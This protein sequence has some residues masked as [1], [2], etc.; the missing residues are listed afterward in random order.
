MGKDVRLDKIDVSAV[1]NFYREWSTVSLRY[2]A[3]LRLE[4]PY[5][6]KTRRTLRALTLDREYLLRKCSN[7]D[8]YIKIITRGT[9]IN[10]RSIGS[11]LFLYYYYYCFFSEMTDLVEH[12]EKCRALYAISY[13]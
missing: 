9:E 8:L 4:D 6:Y 10:T 7:A 2:E 11:F 12:T 3:D 13:R 5:S 1:L